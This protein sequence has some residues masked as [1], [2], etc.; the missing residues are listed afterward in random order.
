VN[1]VDQFLSNTG[2]FSGSFIG[3]HTGSFTG[4][5]TGSLLGT[6]S[7]A[8]S[9]SQ[10]LTASYY[11]ETDPIFVAK[12]AS[13]ATTGSN[14][15]VGN[16]VVTG[17]FII[18]T[19]SSDAAL[20]VT[21]TGTGEAIR[22]EDS[23]NPDAT[24]FVIDA[25]G[26]LQGQAN[27]NLVNSISSIGVN[28][29][30]QAGYALDVSGGIRA[31]GT[32]GTITAHTAYIPTIS[33]ASFI[34]IQSADTIELTPGAAWWVDINAS[35]SAGNGQGEIRFGDSKVF[36]TGYLGS[37]AFIANNYYPGAYDSGWI[38]YTGRAVRVEYPILLDS[39]FPSGNGQ[40]E[41]VLPLGLSTLGSFQGTYV[42]F[43]DPNP[44][45]NHPPWLYSTI[46]A[47]NGQISTIQ[48]GGEAAASVFVSV[49]GYV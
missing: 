14:I 19:A 8:D 45:F 13:L 27:L 30:P 34:N 38:N 41:F 26:A 10:A 36:I 47:A 39:S 35:N 37:E 16:Q 7:W 5:F 49:V 42:G 24:P 40:A 48:V 21:Q 25:T 2:S 43:Q 6:A 28:K 22:V 18:D 4:S 29:I 12:S 17:S 31:A 23:T 15:F 44:S 11:Q 1:R 32:N 20:R 9:A 33:T 3:T 46:N